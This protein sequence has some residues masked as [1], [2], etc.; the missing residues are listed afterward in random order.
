M[1]LSGD[2]YQ[3]KKKKS[4]YQVLR[5]FNKGKTRNAGMWGRQNKWQTCS[6]QSYLVVAFAFMFAASFL[7][8]G[9]RK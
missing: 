3:I 8:V 2:L 4:T 5:I 9:K 7:A 1:M 6:G